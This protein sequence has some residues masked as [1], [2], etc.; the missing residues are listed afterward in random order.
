MIRAV[1]GELFFQVL[2]KELND[3]ARQYN[4]SVSVH[5]RGPGMV[6]IEEG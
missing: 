2:F 5:F 6:L 4:G 3:W 1:I